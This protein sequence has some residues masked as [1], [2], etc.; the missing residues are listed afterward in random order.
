MNSNWFEFKIP[1]FR[2]I[3]H[4]LPSES[5][6]WHFSEKLD[7]SSHFLHFFSDIFLVDLACEML[8]FSFF[9][10]P[11]FFPPFPPCFSLFF[12]L[13]FFLFYAASPSGARARARATSAV[14]RGFFKVWKLPFLGLKIVDLDTKRQIVYDSHINFTAFLP[15]TLILLPFPLP[16]SSSLPPSP[17]SPRHVWWRLRVCSGR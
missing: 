1:N 6:F 12:F 4:F 14:R 17:L 15:N 2:P 11:P 16:S 8:F 7:F 3:F 10:F 13:L 5:C 9:I